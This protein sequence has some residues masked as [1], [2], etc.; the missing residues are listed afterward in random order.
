M[1]TRLN[2]SLTGLIFMAYLP[3]LAQGRI[4]PPDFPHPHRPVDLPLELRQLHVDVRIE[5]QL[6]I[7]KVEHRFYN[8]GRA[9][10]EGR[11][12]YALPRGAQIRQFKMIINGKLTGAELL[13]AKEAA[14]IYEDIVRKMRDPALLEAMG[15]GLIQA[16]VFP[17]EARS[18]K[19]ITLEYQELLTS[20]D[21]LSSYVFPI[22]PGNSGA[23]TDT[24]FVLN[25]DLHSP[26]PLKTIWS[27]SHKLDVHKES[28]RHAKAS[29]EA[30]NHRAFRD[31]ELLYSHNRKPVGIDVLTHTDR[32][33]NYVLFNLTPPFPDPTEK[34]PIDLILILDTSGSMA[35][36]KIDQAKAALIHCLN[37]LDRLDRFAIVRFSTGAEAF[38]TDFKNGDPDTKRQAKKFVE[39]FE[40]LGGT[41][42]QAAFEIAAQ[43]EP[44]GRRPQVTLFLTDGK[45][46]IGERD[47]D[48]LLQKISNLSQRIFPVGIGAE[49]NTH[50]L[51][52][53]AEKTRGRRTYVRS[54]ED[55]EFKISRLFSKIQAP[56]LTDLELRVRGV[57]IQQTTPNELPDLY[58]GGSLLV[59]GTYT[60]QG[61]ATIELS[62]NLQGTRKTYRSN[63]HF[64]KTSFKHDFIPQLW[65]R[66][67]VGFLLDQIRL[68]GE[69]DE[70]K[71]EI[72]RLAKRYGLL[73][74]Y[75]SYL[76]LEDKADQD[77]AVN[78]SPRRQMVQPASESE[79]RQLRRYTDAL[80]EESGRDSVSASRAIQE[81]AEADAVVAKK[82]V[83][84][85][86]ALPGNL[87]PEKI[88]IRAGRAFY[89]RDGIWTD[90]DW[91]E[92]SDQKVTEMTYGSETYFQFLKS[93]PELRAI[94]ALG[95]RIHFHYKGKNYRI[96]AS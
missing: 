78:P 86:E 18:E 19:V 68:F 84:S 21:G 40:A 7:T 66:R 36:E 11:F 75:T 82:Q 59:M 6:A 8:P 14:K 26:S 24:N 12:Y 16:R 38:A 39:S 87:G 89:L 91:Q 58:Q 27:P 9:W 63:H 30:K 47:N 77:V 80:R 95:Q 83:G 55:L 69:S 50:L 88:E 10:K 52:R 48:A 3:L 17:I 49:I 33:G 70:I 74:P 85:G 92:V 76:I 35:G 34:P 25:L 46:T 32:H 44:E 1:K 90:S 94:L 37:Q 54:D 43:Y 61:Q 81:M 79:Q 45:P 31:F 72:V 28:A 62:G 51:D 57:R 13:E 65:A 64:P 53:I 96:N 67:R 4:L 15:S 42:I 71:Q 22:K 29:F 5:N 2:L 23:Y 56:L 20:E 93:N 73:T 41:N 60:G